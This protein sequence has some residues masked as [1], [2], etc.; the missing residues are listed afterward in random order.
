MKKRLF[1]G[2]EIS[3]EAKQRIAECTER[4]RNQFRTLKV[5][6]E[7]PEKYHITLKFLGDV[8][9]ANLESIF[10]STSMIAS[11]FEPISLATGNSGVFPAVKNPKILWFGISDRM[12][13]LRELALLFDLEF[14]KLGL[15]SE[16]R[17]FH[18]HLTIA[19]IREPRKAATLAIAHLKERIE[20]IEFTVSEIVIF[21][22]QLN[23]TGSIYF[24]LIKIPI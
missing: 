14:E 5:G 15:K 9:V 24:P 19:R 16:R 13:L 3:G 6:W 12:K 23:P 11:K 18:P 2:L 21:E 22:S 8:N 20:P 7:Q 10:E 4:L 17:K 1:V